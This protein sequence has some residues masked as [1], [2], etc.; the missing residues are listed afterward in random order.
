MTVG[1]VAASAKMSTKK[2]L[3]PKEFSLEEQAIAESM[4]ARMK[5]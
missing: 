5:E 2:A 3:P 4:P 1:N